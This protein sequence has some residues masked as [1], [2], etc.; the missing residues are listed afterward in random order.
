MAVV[1]RLVT[2]LIVAGLSVP[3]WAATL[4]V[5]LLMQ[6]AVLGISNGQ[7]IAYHVTGPTRPACGLPCSQSFLS[8]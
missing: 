2:G 6:A 4:A 5:A 3:A 8:A 1:V 7:P